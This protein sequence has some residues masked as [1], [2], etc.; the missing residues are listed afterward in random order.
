[1]RPLQV[2]LDV[3]D[4]CAHLGKLRL[5]FGAETVAEHEKVDYTSHKSAFGCKWGSKLGAL[6]VRLYVHYHP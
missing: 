4:D 1:M 2:Q 5:S 3:L 6:P